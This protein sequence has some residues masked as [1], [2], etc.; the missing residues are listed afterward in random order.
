MNVGGSALF[1]IAT[2]PDRRFRRT[3]AA[4]WILL[5]AVMAAYVGVIE[6]GPRPRTAYGLTFQVTAQKIV[7]TALFAV[8]VLQSVEA[9]R[10][11][12]AEAAPRPELQT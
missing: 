1:A 9:E 5:T 11:A 2:V 10:I 7:I 8:I 6:W 12:A 3:A 4:A